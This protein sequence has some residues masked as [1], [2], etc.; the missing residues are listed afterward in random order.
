MKLIVWYKNNNK[1]LME[2]IKR[3]DIEAKSTENMIKRPEA[4]FLNC[5]NSLTSGLFLII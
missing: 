4:S 3:I 2:S 1:N 5:Q